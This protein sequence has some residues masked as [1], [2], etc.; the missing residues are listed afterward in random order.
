MNCG[1]VTKIA[2]AKAL[3]TGELYCS[4]E[5]YIVSPMVYPPSTGKIAPVINEAFFDDKNTI[6]LEMSII[7]AYLPIG[8]FL[9]R[10]FSD[11]VAIIEPLASV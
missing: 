10:S 7:L 4:P 5:I 1:L 8:I 2:K 9:S 6:A 3:Y 11:Y